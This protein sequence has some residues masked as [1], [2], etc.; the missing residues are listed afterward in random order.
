MLSK[1]FLTDVR[2]RM[3]EIRL[4]PHTGMYCYFYNFATNPT[5]LRTRDEHHVCDCIAKWCR[6]QLK[7]HK[8]W[9]ECENG[10]LAL[11]KGD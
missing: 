7:N 3:N 4:I 9:Y 11:L 10:K 2:Q 8:G 6:K 5:V 1:N